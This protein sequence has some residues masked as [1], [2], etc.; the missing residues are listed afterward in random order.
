MPAV[1]RNAERIRS[2]SQCNN[3]AHLF[4][5]T[6]DGKEISRQ[7]HV[8]V[9][10]IQTWKFSFD[11]KVFLGFRDIHGRQPFLCK[12]PHRRCFTKKRSQ[13][14]S[15]S[16]RVGVSVPNGLHGINSIN[17]SE[18]LQLIGIIVLFVA[19]FFC[20]P[21][22]MMEYWIWKA[23]NNTFYK[24]C[25]V[26]IFRWYSSG[27]HFLL[28]LP[29]LLHQNKKINAKICALNSLF[30]KPII[31]IGA[32]P[33]S[34]TSFLHALAKPQLSRQLNIRILSSPCRERHLVTPPA[35]LFPEI[36][37]RIDTFIAEPAISVFVLEIFQRKRRLVGIGGHLFSFVIIDFFSHGILL[38]CIR[39]T[40]DY[41]VSTFY[42]ST[43]HAK[44]NRR[45]KLRNCLRYFSVI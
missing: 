36:F 7:A 12:R 2:I 27:S 41:V 43:I 20:K 3:G 25:C 26:Y 38:S 31:P 42:M 39:V 28:L 6:F 8:Y 35:T 24:K 18:F 32:K 33:L 44:K 40:L 10:C 37:I 9:F 29:K 34:S 23:E 17:V 19:I 16:L 45:A 4:L 15:S 11:D 13:S 22:G 21:H 1:E 5:L 14:L 30:L